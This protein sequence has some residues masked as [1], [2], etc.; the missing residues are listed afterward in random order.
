MTDQSGSSPNLLDPI[1]DSIDAE[2][3]LVEDKA[4]YEPEAEWRRTNLTSVD[5]IAQ[6]EA[7]VLRAA[8]SVI[9]TRS[10]KWQKAHYEQ[11]V[12]DRGLDKIMLVSLNNVQLSQNCSPTTL[13]E[14][15]TSFTKGQT[16][17]LHSVDALMREGSFPQNPMFPTKTWRSLRVSTTEIEVS[18]QQ[19]AQMRFLHKDINE[20]LAPVL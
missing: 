6:R 16:I 4:G 15:S 2:S 18:A 8:F 3:P 9:T 7:F 19:I 14:L 13:R 20:K 1:V 11:E 5:G 12:I 10:A 17:I